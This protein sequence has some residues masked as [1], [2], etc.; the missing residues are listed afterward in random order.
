MGRIKVLI[1]DDQE[2]FASGIEIILTGRGKD[3]LHVVGKAA[4][5]REAVSMVASL[6]P[7]V[8]LMDVRMPVMDGVE[9]TRI[10]VEQ[11]PDVKILILTTFDDDQY[12]LDA[13]NNGALGY[14]LKNIS[15]ADPITSIKAVHNGNFFVSSSVGY[16][17]VRRAEEGTRAM[18]EADTK[19]QG[20][21]NYLM[22]CFDSLTMREAEVL[23]LLMMDHDNHEIAE[24]LFVAEQTV[25]N[26]I[27][28]IYS[29]LGV[30]DR[31]HAKRHVNRVLASVRGR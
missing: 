3:D 29:K 7:D 5:G 16:K 13:L 30:P 6:R 4:D 2:L 8:V 21:L 15:P 31:V 1:V 24:R 25:K 27:S 14:I 18:E 26:R 22:S 11:Y 9:A 17:L 23:H 12:V 19:Y 20:E 28:V 10:I